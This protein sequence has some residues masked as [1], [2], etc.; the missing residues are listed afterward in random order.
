MHVRDLWGCEKLQSSKYLVCC[1]SKNVKSSRG[2]I[3]RV[4]GGDIYNHSRAALV[5]ILTNTLVGHSHHVL[6]IKPVFLSAWFFCTANIE[7]IEKCLRYK[8]KPMYTL[9]SCTCVPST[10]AHQ[11]RVDRL[12][13]VSLRVVR[14]RLKAVA[15]EN[16]HVT[17][18][19]TRADRLRTF[20]IP[21]FD[22]RHVVLLFLHCNKPWRH[23]QLQ[24]AS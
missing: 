8:V 12:E 17:A 19:P 24:I 3:S 15:I 16:L 20:A 18:V 7:N 2:C 23:Q 6:P 4:R 1:D 10:D 22:V 14:L 9:Q 21:H 5:S 13:V 11:P